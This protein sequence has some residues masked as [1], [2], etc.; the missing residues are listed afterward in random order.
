MI[1]IL[2]KKGLHNYHILESLE[3]GIQLNGP[4]VKSIRDGRIDLGQSH[5]KILNGEV[6]LINANIPVY[7]NAPIKD[8]DPVRT[9]K[10]LLHHDQI[11][12]LFGKLSGKGISLIP[13]SIYEKNN[14]VKVQLGLGKAKKE[15]DKRRVLK[16]RDHLRRIEQEIRGKE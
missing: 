12:S 15:F 6:Y 2:N 5:A 7:Q 4:E 3:A 13:V 10:L 1:K 8:Y 11:Q 14:M 16:E 9:R